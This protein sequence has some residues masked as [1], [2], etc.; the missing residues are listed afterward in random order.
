MSP[1]DCYHCGLPCPAADPIRMAWKGEERSFCC[2]GCRAAFEL[3]VASGLDAFYR[4]R[5]TQNAGRPEELT[6]REWELLHSPVFQAHHVRATVEGEVETD[7][8]LGGIHCAACVWLNEQVLQRL[9]GVVYA[10]VN[11]ST[12]RA[13][14]RWRAAETTLA[15]IIVAVRRI[16]YRAEPFDSTRL[17]ARRQEQSRDLLLRLGVAGFGA[18]NI[19]TIAVALYAGYFQGMA[20][21]YK[22]F[23]HLVSWLIA[24]PVM[25]FSGW[26]FLRGA[27]NGLRL[28]RVTMDLPIVL[29][30][31]ITYAYSVQVFLAGQGE[32][33]FD[34][35]CTFLFFLLIG[36]YLELAARR[37][38]SQA[39]ERLLRLEPLEATLLRPEGPTVVPVTVV[40]MGDRLLIRP[41]ERFPVDG[42]IESGSTAT[43]ESPLTGESLPQTRGPGD[44]VLA[45]ANN[46]DGAVTIRATGVGGNTTLARMARLV[47]AA[48]N[49]RS[50]LQTLADRVARHFVATILLLAALTLAY[51]WSRGAEQAWQH[52]VAL[53]IITCPCALGLATPVA[54]AVASGTAAQLGILIKQGIALEQLAKADLI[55]LDKTGTL[56]CGQPDVV[57]LHPTPGMPASRLLALAALAEQ[58][59]EHPIAHAIVAKAQSMAIVLSPV[60]A[61][62]LRNYPGQGVEVVG[63]E[64]MIHVGSRAFLQPFLV[65]AATEPSPDSHITWV[66][67]ALNRK[68]LGW[69]ALTDTLKPDAQA[70]VRQLRAMQ[71]EVWLLSGDREAV[72]ER[73]GSAVGV[74]RAKGGVLPEEK[75]RIVRAEQAAGRRVVMVGDGLNDAPALARANVGITVDRAV[76]LSVVAAGVALLNPRLE[77]L[78]ILIQ[79]ARRTMRVIRENFA[80]SVLYN[81]LAIPLAMTGHV[82][83]VVAA[84]AM[85]LSSLAVVVNALRLRR[86]EHRS[87]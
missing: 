6:A 80:L 82:L 22:H 24:T 86:V 11:F 73:V 9:P 45:G 8:L 59:S 35:V 49:D 21:Q 1:P 25:L 68:L 16:G 58:G 57:A 41:G 56:T 70:T 55:I 74:D 64:G 84:I 17:P 50:P 14:V 72:V 34:S 31:L 61:T 13:L 85:P 20:S 27:W 76:G 83:P 18:G 69:I 67:C 78:A 26:P 33:Y 51:W 29:G 3:I 32:V 46:I 7:L 23:F 53:L 2:P 40:G 71:L 10:R 79:L 37:K 52:A 47:E 36:R 5:T 81:V 38:S 77:M 43:D 44:A 62:T 12:H 28:R 19:M 63:P 48:Q 15:D 66:G 65:E 75:E 4:Q 39:T 42:V 30:F 87:A 60:D 54:F